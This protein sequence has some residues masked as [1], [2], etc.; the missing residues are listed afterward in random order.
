MIKKIAFC[1]LLVL[2]IVLLLK[3]YLS[4]YSI[5]YDLDGYSILEKYEDGKYYF[6]ISKDDFV[7]NFLVFN[8]RKLTKKLLESVNLF[9]GENYDCLNP[10]LNGLES[11]PLCYN[12]EKELIHFSMI[13]DED[14]LGYLD[15]LNLTISNERDVEDEFYFS[16]NLDDN[17]Y[18][19]VWKYN[20]FY[21]L[22]GDGVKTLD[23]FETDRYSNNLSNLHENKLFFPN[24]DEDLFFTKF[25]LLDITD[26]NY[27][28]FETDYEI[29]YDSYISGTHKKNIYLFDNKNENLYEINM[30]NGRIELIGSKETGYIKYENGKKVGAELNEYKKDKVMY[31][32]LQYNNLVV[33]NNSYFYTYNEEVLTRFIDNEDFNVSY[34]YNNDVYY[35]YKDNLYRFNPLSGS[36]LVLHYFELNFNDSNRIFIYNK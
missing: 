7:V 10:I 28:I 19:A 26:G 30:K 22:N 12:S 29:S 25:I 14:V 23:I 4:D 5:K 9:D 31:F 32:D 11:Y 15:S 18:I 33:L 16:D 13:S 20:G 8:N 35:I 27:K 2:V 34:I 3:F 17:T 36:E 21:L 1:V 24:Y 6:E